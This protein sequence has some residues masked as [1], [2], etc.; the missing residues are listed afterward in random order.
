MD[1]GASRCRPFLPA[2]LAASLV[3]LHVAWGGEQ[4]KIPEGMKLVIY[5]V[6]DLV[7]SLSVWPDTPKEQMS[8][9]LR[10]KVEQEEREN[11]K[12]LGHEEI[13]REIKL[14]TG[15]AWKGGASIEARGGRLVVIQ[16]PEM[17]KRTSDILS[18]IRKDPNSITTRIGS[19]PDEKA[20]EGT[21]GEGGE[22]GKAQL[23]VLAAI[24]AGLIV[25]LVLI[26]HVFRSAKRNRGNPD[27]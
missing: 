19:S 26:I 11:A 20:S 8:P 9:E 1:R 24:A 21:S 22:H 18:A 10:R 6:R 16:T 15:Q 14:R 2:F 4:P 25:V 23:A 5:D 17:H 12:R 7:G 13:I 27:A 3:M